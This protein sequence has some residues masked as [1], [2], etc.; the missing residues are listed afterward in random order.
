MRDWKTF[1][2]GTAALVGLVV[3]AVALD[4][5][6][7]A[8]SDTEVPIGQAVGLQPTRSVS[9]REAAEGGHSFGVEDAPV[10][11]VA[12]ADFECPACAHFYRNT[13]QSAMRRHSNRLRV[14]F[15]HWPLTYH[16]HA[17]DAARALECAATDGKSAA[18]HDA[19]YASHDTLANVDFVTLARQIGVTVG[20]SALACLSD[21]TRI[22]AVE[23]DIDLV[24]AIGGKGTPTI[25]I[26]GRLVRGTPDSARLENL[27]MNAEQ[28][29]LTVI[30]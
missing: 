26:N 19:L 10:T 9:W 7:R 13:L 5:K 12:F 22:P 21:T 27:I 8:K 29:P 30:K 15:R 6:L 25:I 23:A 4:R 20:P 28:P 14:V 1:A 17:Y 11:L 18:M 24:Q 16:E 3:S 2:I